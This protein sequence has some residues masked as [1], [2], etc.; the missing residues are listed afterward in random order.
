VLDVFFI[1]GSILA[2]VFMYFNGDMQAVIEAQKAA[3]AASGN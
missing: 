1:T 2:A 3:Q